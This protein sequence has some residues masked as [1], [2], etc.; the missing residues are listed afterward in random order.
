MDFKTYQTQSRTTAQ[1]PNV[2]DNMQYLGLGLAEEGGE[3]AGKVKKLMRNEGIT[4]VHNLTDAHREMIVK[5]LGDVLWY[6]TQFAVEVG[7]S[8]EEVAQ[9]NIDKLADR[10]ARNVIASKGDAR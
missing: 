10:A 6:L 1:Y 5:E 7:S 8:L 9:V 4:S 2:G 3:V